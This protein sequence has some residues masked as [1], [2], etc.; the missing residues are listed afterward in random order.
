VEHV[1]VYEGGQAVVGNVNQT[2]QATA[3]IAAESAA[4]RIIEKAA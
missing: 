1:H 4:L 3:Q 2:T